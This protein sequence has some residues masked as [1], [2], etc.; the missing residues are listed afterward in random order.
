MRSLTTALEEAQRATTAAH[1][2]ARQQL[3][4]QAEKH[5]Q[6]R[7]RHAERAAATE[8]HHL[9]EIDRARSEARSLAEQLRQGDAAQRS[10]ADKLQAARE[11][12]ERRQA[13]LASTLAERD[14]QLTQ[15]RG[16]FAA[17]QQTSEARQQLAAANE[18]RVKE[19]AEALTAARRNEDDLRRQLQARGAARAEDSPG[20]KAKKNS[21]DKTT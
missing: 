10:L 19:L 3:A 12:A 7:Q 21:G 15:T 6:E 9:Q 17:A 13:E 5:A 18:A 2:S 8:R 11:A 1:A 16:A 4:E 20:R 14:S